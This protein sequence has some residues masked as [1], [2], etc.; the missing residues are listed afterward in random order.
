MFDAHKINAIDHE[1]RSSSI[2]IEITRIRLIRQKPEDD[3]EFKEFFPL[4]VR[5]KGDNFDY[6]ITSQLEAV[7]L[8]SASSR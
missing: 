7:R 3:P 8:L 5:R 2:S 1:S 6:L 4:K